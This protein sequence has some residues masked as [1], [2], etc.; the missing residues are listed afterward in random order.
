MRPA[1]PGR[2]LSGEDG[3]YEY[4]LDLAE[5]AN[6]PD[7]DG[8]PRPDEIL[9]HYELPEGA[10]RPA[11][12]SDQPSSDDEHTDRG[13]L[14]P[15]GDEQP[16]PTRSW[17]RSQSTMGGRGSAARRLRREVRRTSAD[18]AQNSAPHISRASARGVAEIV[19]V[20]GRC[21][22]AR[23]SADRRS[24]RAVTHSSPSLTSSCTDAGRRRVSSGRGYRREPL[25]DLEPLSAVDINGPG[26]RAAAASHRGGHA[27]GCE[28]SWPVV[29]SA[30][31]LNLQE[32]CRPA[33]GRA[34]TDTCGGSITSDE[35]HTPS[36]TRTTTQT[37]TTVSQSSS[38]TPAH[39]HRARAARAGALPRAHRRRATGP[40]RRRRARARA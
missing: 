6:M 24:K 3:G 34:R 20:R 19:A 2:D 12:D 39:L 28:P 15:P 31:S 8:K 13:Q 5:T 36:T 1:R 30:S 7:E 22:H 16:S 14:G 35:D 37:T 33:E 26:R 27:R 29:E 4:T 9:A 17:R 18:G 23:Y 25:P 32:S 40:P 10:I 21:V 11:A 38:T